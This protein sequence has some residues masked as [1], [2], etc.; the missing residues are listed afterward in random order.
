MN[1][2][3]C[4]WPKSTWYSPTFLKIDYELSKPVMQTLSFDDFFM[5]HSGSHPV[6][7]IGNVSSFLVE[8]NT[9]SLSPAIIMSIWKCQ[10]EK[11]ESR[12]A[13]RNDK[14][15]EFLKFWPQI[16]YEIKRDF[17]NHTFVKMSFGIVMI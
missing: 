15:P 6:L 10:L 11:I 13:A 3:F 9:L 7:E 1:I 8:P 4:N 16:D 12:R 17:L 5:V 14:T 2:P